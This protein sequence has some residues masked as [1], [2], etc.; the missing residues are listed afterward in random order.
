MYGATAQG[1]AFKTSYFDVSG[2]QFYYNT[3]AT[4]AEL[5]SGVSNQGYFYH[6]PSGLCLT[7]EQTSGTDPKYNNAKITLQPCGSSATP[8]ENQRWFSDHYDTTIQ[9]YCFG[10][11][12]D[13]LEGYAWDGNFYDPD[14][15]GPQDAKART[16]ASGG[17]CFEFTA[18]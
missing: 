10:L 4:A 9:V 16:I 18:S 11:I 12:D 7:L 2:D 6:V 5:Q 8:P 13:T 17:T 15:P 14:T 3:T 1:S